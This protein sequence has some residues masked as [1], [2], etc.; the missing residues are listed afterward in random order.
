[1]STEPSPDLTVQQ[2]TARAWR[3]DKSPARKPLNP[4]SNI[5]LKEKNYG[6]YS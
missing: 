4:A 2:F 5:E 3:A 6:R 1:M